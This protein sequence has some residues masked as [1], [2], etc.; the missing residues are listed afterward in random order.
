MTGRATKVR[1][2]SRSTAG[3]SAATVA[4]TASASSRDSDAS[5]RRSLLPGT[6]AKSMPA[7]SRVASGAGSGVAAGLAVGVA[8]GNGEG[9]DDAVGRAR[10]EGDGVSGGAVSG[11]HAAI[12]TRIAAR[13]RV[14]TE[15]AYR[16]SGGV[17]LILR[18]DARRDTT[19]VEVSDATARCQERQAQAS[20]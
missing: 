17:V 15:K 19:F 1:S 9:S 4:A 2:N 7:I 6:S 14:V 10:G 16:R 18:R 20:V 11:P 3:M 12:E 8:V 5:M 13:S